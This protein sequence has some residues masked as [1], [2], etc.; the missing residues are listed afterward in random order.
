MRLGVLLIHGIGDQGPDWADAIIRSLE[1]RVLEQLRSL[2]DQPP[3]DAGSVLRVG[4]VHWADVLAKPQR[5]LRRVLDCAHASPTAD[6]LWWFRLLGTVTGSLRRQESRFI[7]EFIGDVIGYRSP[8]TRQAI[9]D[10]ITRAL[11]QLAASL[12][13]GSEQAPLTLVAHSLGSVIASDYV[14]DLTKAHRAHPQQGVHDRWRF[15]N[16]FTVGSPMALF[17][18]QYGGA[19]AFNKPIALEHPRGRWVNLY[20]RDD[21]LGMPLRPLNEAYRRVVLADAE[22]HAGAYLFAHTR[23]FT[24]RETLAIISRKLA[25]DWCAQNDQLPAPRWRD[26]SAAYDR[27]LGRLAGVGRPSAR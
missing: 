26:L 19:A 5:E 4:R 10:T 23:Y 12:E 1:Q 13:T 21:P 18:L 24:N 22:V 8:E 16:F 14:W 27:T 6:G 15:E 2:L 11:D 20:D 7:A 25:L 9:Y 17:A 3:L